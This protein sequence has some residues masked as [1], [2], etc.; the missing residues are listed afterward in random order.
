MVITHRVQEF[1]IVLINNNFI[2]RKNSLI[3]ISRY[4]QLFEFI[5]LSFTGPEKLLAAVW[6]PH[7]ILMF[8]TMKE[9]SFTR[10]KGLH[11]TLLS[12]KEITLLF[13][14]CNS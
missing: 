14:R 6:D 11:A 7:I 8:T 9:I 2:A 1:D 10:C 12:A 4:L 5:F 3:P 13:L